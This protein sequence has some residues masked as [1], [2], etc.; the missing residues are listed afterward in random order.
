MSLNGHIGAARS[1][2]RALAVSSA[3]FLSD[4]INLRFYD[5]AKNKVA[6]DNF[7]LP[8]VCGFHQYVYYDSNVVLHLDHT[9]KIIEYDCKYP[10]LFTPDRFPTPP[11]PKNA[12]VNVKQEKKKKRQNKTETVFAFPILL[13]K[14]PKA[15]WWSEEIL[16]WTCK[17]VAID[18]HDIMIHRSTIPIYIAYNSTSILN[19]FALRAL[20][21]TFFRHPEGQIISN[22]RSSIFS[23]CEGQGVSWEEQRN[24]MPN[25]CIAQSWA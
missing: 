11:P 10:T 14:V 2:L 22:I 9:K 16:C 8:L 21:L 25:T 6:F 12:S 3:C 23:C 17:W 20:H 13:Q 18:F 24:V 4:L 1:L 5:W 7:R 19:K 15:E